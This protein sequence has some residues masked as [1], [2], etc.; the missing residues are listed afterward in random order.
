MKLTRR[1]LTTA[2]AAAPFASLLP[3]TAFAQDKIVLGFAQVGAETKAHGQHRSIKSSAKDAGIEL[4]F[5]DAQQK[6][7]NQ[8]KAI[9]RTSHRR[10]TSSPSRRS[11]KPAGTRLRKPRPPRSQWC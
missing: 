11:W 2:L 7:E 5:S 6:Q 9:T 1:T 8:I 10:S 4:K 3:A